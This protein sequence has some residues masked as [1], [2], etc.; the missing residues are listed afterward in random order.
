M[1]SAQ[2]PI[3][4]RHAGLPAFALKRPVTVLMALLSAIL[5]GIVAYLRLP[6]SLAPDSLDNPF[7]FISMPYPASDPREVEQKIAKPVEEILGSV[8]GIDQLRSFSNETGATFWV[9][10]KQ[11]AKVDSVYTEV[12]DRLERIRKD[13]PQ[14]LDR[15]YVYRWRGTDWPVLVVGFTANVNEPDELYRIIDEKVKVRLQ[16]IDGVASVETEGLRKKRVVV[17]L[18]QDRLEAHNIGLAAVYQAL[19]R[20]NFTL[21]GGKVEQSGVQHYVRAMAKLDSI[22]ELANLRLPGTDL[23]LS[24]VADVAAELPEQERVTQVDGRP[25]V[26]LLVKKESKA[27]TVKVCEAAQAVIDDLKSDPETRALEH[28]YFFNQGQMVGSS[29]EN[30]VSSG[31][32]GGVFAVLILYAFL[33]RLR[34]T[35]L[36]AMAI[37]LS[38]LVTLMVLYFLGMNLNLGSMLGLMIGIGMLVDNAIVVVENIFRLRDEGLGPKEAAL[39]G[40]SEVG[41]AITAS[42]GT[43][44]IV[45]LPLLFMSGPM[46]AWMYEIGLPV[47]ISVIVSLLVALTLI[48]LA[49]AHMPMG[50]LRF[51]EG[52]ISRLRE[53]YGKFL[54]ATLRH[55]TETLIGVLLVLAGTALVGSKGLSFTDDPGSDDRRVNMHLHHENAKTLEGSKQV[56]F[57]VGKILD[58]HREELEVQNLY[59]SFDRIHGDIDLFLTPKRKQLSTEEVAQRV[60]EI[61]PKIPGTIERVNGSRQESTESISVLLQGED[62]QLLETFAEDAVRRLRRVQGVLDLNTGLDE[63]RDEIDVTIDRH[64]SWRQGLSPEAIAGAL[65]LGVRGRKVGVFRTADRDLDIV[66]Q[67]GEE[68]RQS[69]D[70]LRNLPLPVRDP[71]ASTAE[72]AGAGGQ[73]QAEPRATA[74]AGNVPLST[75]ASFRFAR[76]LGEIQRQRGMASLEIKV[77]TTEKD[78]EALKRRITQA[79]DGFSMPRG[80]LWTYGSRFQRQNDDQAQSSLSAVLATLLVFLIMGVLFESFLHPL[81]VMLTLPFAWLGFVWMMAAT[82]TPVDILGS[83]GLI[84][85]IGVVVNNSIVVVDRINQLRE[86]GWDRERALVQAG[87]DRMRPVLMTALTTTLGLVPMALDATLFQYK[88]NEFLKALGLGFLQ[89]GSGTTSAILY[90]SLGRSIMGGL[91]AGT[92]STLLLTPYFYLLFDELKLY[93]RR[94]FATLWPGR[95]TEA[96]T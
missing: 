41:V 13:L 85:L 43:T 4:D 19:A 69:L 80:Y 79:L 11:D 78:L 84:V 35:V 27:N 24:A 44:S 26:V 21:S 88:F 71:G 34:P 92:M 72:A 76:A 18:R 54:A 7:L 74:A 16:R 93:L 40:A 70:S 47:S 61:L 28:F 66:L 95:K 2:H 90:S 3:F 83:V 87:K 50:D 82:R 9:E 30:L 68:N 25:T 86:A 52:R 53:R 94:L 23:R 49:M 62:S 12:K 63:R 5:L 59:M 10:L 20:S 75:V 96:S 1:T 42:T 81:T 31:M 60:R 55:R 36:I 29:L 58:Q 14:D 33:R 8:K 65:S 38:I 22:E 46:G 39:R 32:W 17:K 56:F 67:L 73:P 15:T 89:L 37:P 91:I 77:T 51:D 57:R 48:P 6:L 64:R 45:F